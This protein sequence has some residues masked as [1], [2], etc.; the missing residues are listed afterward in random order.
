MTGT[1]FDGKFTGKVPE[2]DAP[3]KLPVDDEQRRQWQ[4]AN[5][6]WWEELPMRYDW[7]EELVSSLS[8]VD[9]FAQIDQ[10]FF[11]RFAGFYLGARSLSTT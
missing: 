3:T 9:Y 11:R 7:R 2:F 10:R 1:A 5:K 4:L 8:T 6:A